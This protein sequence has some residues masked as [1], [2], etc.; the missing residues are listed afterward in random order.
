MKHIHKFLLFGISLLA[1]V[2]CQE[3]TTPANLSGVD[4]IPIYDPDISHA[5]SLINEHELIP[6]ET[7]DDCLIQSVHQLHVTDSFMYVV[8]GRMKDIFIFDRQGKYLNKISNQG[9]GPDEYIS[10]NGFSVNPFNQQLILSDTFSKRIFLYSPQ[11]KQLQTIQLDFMPMQIVA[12]KDGSFFNIYSGSNQ[13]YESEEMEKHH[14]HTIDY[15]GNVQT[16]FLPDQTQKRIDISSLQTPNYSQEGDLLYKPELGDI[17]Y[18]ITR[19]GEYKPLY[20]FDNHSSLR[21]P[22]EK[23][24]NYIRYIYGKTNDYERLEKEKYLLSSSGFL[25]TAHSMFFLF[26]WNNRI[27]LFYSKKTGQ[28]V[29]FSQEQIEKEGTPLCKVIFIKAPCTVFDDS[30]YTTINYS[31]REYLSTLISDKEILEQL[32]PEAKTENNPVVLRY[33]ISL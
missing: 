16:C 25:D 13:F 23:E 14:I 5:D 12:G 24:R 1:F 27:L 10:I 4:R 6:L 11:G 26:G 17:V 8:D 28:S 29:A 22:T 33:R 2:A 21:W 3:K 31:D 7:T 32:L 18:Q 19:A 9:Q 15:N 30:Y 20:T